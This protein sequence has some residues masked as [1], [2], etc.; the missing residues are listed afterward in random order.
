MEG[1]GVDILGNTMNSEAAGLDL[2]GD[3]GEEETE[4]NLMSRL[5]A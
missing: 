5:L 4:M 3:G 1:V 2:L